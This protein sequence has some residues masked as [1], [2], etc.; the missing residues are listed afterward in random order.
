M[1]IFLVGDSW[2]AMNT[3]QDYG[4]VIVAQG[5]SSSQYWVEYLDNFTRNGGRLNSD[6]VVILNV[7]GVDF[8]HSIP[9]ETTYNNIKHIAQVLSEQGAHIGLVG[10]PNVSS[11]SELLGPIQMDPLYNRIAT[12]VP[13]TFVSTAMMDTIQNQPYLDSSG[14]HLNELGYIKYNKVLQN[15]FFL[16]VSY[17]GINKNKLSPIIY[18]NHY[19]VLDGQHSRIIISDEPYW[20]NQSITDISGYIPISHLYG[21]QGGVSIT[22]NSWDRYGGTA[23]TEQ[24]INLVQQ[25]D[26]VLIDPYIGTGLTEQQLLEFSHIASDYVHSQGKEIYAAVTTY[27]NPSLCQE[28]IHFNN[29]LLSTTNFDGVY[30]VSAKDFYDIPDSWELNLVG[31]VNGHAVPGVFQ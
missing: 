16:N 11:L 20:N 4:A 7:G 1:T 31:V 25:S 29:T 14:F 2:A 5:G 13:N 23:T 9:R 19:M 22:P 30:Y 10:V 26:F 28:T 15:D 12:E 18:D 8:L 17:Q 6:D 27:A 21:L 24:L 3:Y